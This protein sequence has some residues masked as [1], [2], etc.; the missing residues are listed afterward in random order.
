M[1]DEQ[2]QDDELRR[3]AQRLGTSA[4]ERLDVE[5][6]ANG[7][8][9]RLRAE[10]SEARSA[11]PWWSQPGW[12]RAA[13]V[14]VVMVGAGVVLRGR[15]GQPLHP[16][17]YVADDLRDLSTDQLREVLGTLD[18]TLSAPSSIEPSEDDVN[19]LTTEQLQRL[20]QSL[21]G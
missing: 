5:R 16:P 20:L 19:D 15:N 12:L 10:P 21:E 13:A 2:L 11:S 3:L 7:V 18:Q 4:A 1:S 14:V 6:T 17:H 8:V 9:Q